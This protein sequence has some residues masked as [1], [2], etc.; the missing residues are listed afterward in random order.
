MSPYD[1]KKSMVIPFLIPFQ[2]LS[3]NKGMHYSS[4]QKTTF[5]KL[6]PVF[7]HLIKSSLT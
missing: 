7:P 2:N 6:N 4:L 1:S 5:P 3:I